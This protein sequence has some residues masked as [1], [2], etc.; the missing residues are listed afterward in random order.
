MSFM[1]LCLIL[2]SFCCHCVSKSLIFPH[3][4]V[5]VVC[6][7]H[8]IIIVIQVMLYVIHVIVFDLNV[9]LCAMCLTKSHVCTFLLLWRVTNMS[10]LLWL[11]SCCIT[12]MYI[13]VIVLQ[14]L[15]DSGFCFDHLCGKPRNQN[16]NQVNFWQ[17]FQV[18]KFLLNTP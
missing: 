16:F 13:N 7:V 14:I 1:L 3:M 8:V 9:I 12:C 4:S 18:S 15:Q 10:S 2:M 6:H 5:D 17:Y 11:K